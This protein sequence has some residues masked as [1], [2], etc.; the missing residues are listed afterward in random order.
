MSIKIKVMTFNLRVPSESDGINHFDNRKQLVLATIEK[1]QP[2]LIGFQEAPDS[3]RA[4]LR[5]NLPS[6]YTLLGCGRKAGYR[7]E[8]APLAY[9]N[10]RFELIS[11]ETFWL[12][13]TPYVPESRYENSDQSNCPRLTVHATLH[14]EGVEKPF[15]FYN[16]HLDHKGTQAQA[17]GLKLIVDRIDSINPEGY[18]MV[19]T[20]DFNIKPNNPALVDLD[21]R[22]QSTRK[23]A[24]KTDNH[25]T[26]NGWSTAKTDAVIDYISVSGFSACPEYKTV[27]EKYADKELDS[28]MKRAAINGYCPVSVRYPSDE[29][30]TRGNR[31]TPGLRVTTEIG[32]TSSEQYQHH[33][34]L[35]RA[36]THRTKGCERNTTHL[37][38][39]LQQ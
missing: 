22:M 9:R 39:H 15:H 21:A 1:E 20:G 31:I 13:D 30:P 27:I 10:D 14:A 36:G 11:F 6:N 26:F 3:T 4:F 33:P 23:I 28:C 5:A 8:S 7:G 38:S 32:L 35:L 24:D 12:S 37:P 2:D 19:L 34:L 29:D 16:T 17:N 25:H 18:P